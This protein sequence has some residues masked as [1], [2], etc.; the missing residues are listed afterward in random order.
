MDRVDDSAADI[1]TRHP[2]RGVYA[3]TTSTRKG[4]EV[5]CDFPSAEANDEDA[6]EEGG[7]PYA[8]DLVFVG[9]TKTR[10]RE[11]VMLVRHEAAEYADATDIRTLDQTVDTGAGEID[12]WR[13]LQQAH[14]DFETDLRRNG[15]DPYYYRGGPL[16]RDAVTHRSALHARRQ[17]R[18]E[19][20][21]RWADYY[22]ERYESILDAVIL[23]ESKPG[24]HK[25]SRLEDQADAGKSRTTESKFRL[26]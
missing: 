15:I 18:T 8:L 3:A 26:A 4:I 7:G 1:Y 17:I 13:C 6:V 5:L 9:T 16:A 23:G 21:E 10:K 22:A 20:D 11:I 14:R 12:L 24:V 25:P 19:S 2:I